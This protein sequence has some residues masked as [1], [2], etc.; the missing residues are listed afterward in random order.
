MFDGATI[1]V[2]G[3]Y[4]ATVFGLFLTNIAL[5]GDRLHKINSAK[6]EKI[7]RAKLARQKSQK[8]DVAVS[9]RVFKI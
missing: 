5:A 7:A 4:K 2:N 8:E 9:E 1:S 6:H 3:V